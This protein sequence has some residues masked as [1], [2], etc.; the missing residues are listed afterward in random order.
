MCD[1]QILFEVPEE[2]VTGEANAD[3]L[4]EPIS[5]A[6]SPQDYVQQNCSPIK[7]QVPSSFESCQAQNPVNCSCDMDCCY[8][9]PPRQ[10]MCKPMVSYVRPT[11]PIDTN[12]IYKCSYVGNSGYKRVMPIH[13]QDSMQPFQ[14]PMDANT[15]QK[16]SFQP[17][18]QAVR[19]QPIKPKENTQRFNGQFYDLTSQKHDFVPKCYSKRQPL[20]VSDGI[21]K[22]CAPL[23]KCTINKLSYMPYDICNNPPPKPIIQ[24]G[25]YIRPDAPG[26]RCTVQKLSYLPVPLPVKDDMPWAR[27]VHVEPPPCGPLC[28][29][30]KLSFIPNC[31]PKRIPALAPEQAIKIFGSEMPD[32]NTVYKLSY[33]KSCGTKPGL[34]MPR[35]G[36]HLPSGRMEKCTVYK[37]S[38][39]PQNCPERT[40]P[41]RPK[42]NVCRSTE[43]IQDITTQKHDFVPKPNC[44]RGLLVPPTSM[45][46]P[47]CP[48]EK[49]T[50][51]KLSYLPQ[52]NPVKTG[53]ILPRHGLAPIDAPMAKCTTYK[54]S[55]MPVQIPPKEVLPWA[56][57][58]SCMRPTA[59]IERCTIQKLSYGAPGKFIQKGNCGCGY[60]NKT[61]TTQYPKAAV[62]G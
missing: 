34:I 44:R 10:P 46:T 52:V 13:V 20:K 4:Q 5:K 29:T 31:N 23:E 30:Y 33:L 61:M 48:M 17:H 50:I 14:G 6:C 58:T 62:C 32:K 43:P 7:C 53:P 2:N 36:I 39:Q 12:T 55:Y 25:H 40:K 24:T 27:R 22:L 57:Q 9:Q 49:C 3:M 41:C 56:R 47:S 38:F 51:N 18:C 8:E 28:T 59:Q 11:Q 45:C 16:L 42:G 60:S 37:L 35:P 15:I 1:Q 21:I 26:E 54:L 19:A